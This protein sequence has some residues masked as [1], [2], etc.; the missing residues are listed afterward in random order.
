MSSPVRTPRTAQVEDALILNTRGEV[1]ETSAANIFWLRHGSLG[2][3]PIESGALP[4]I[5]RASVLRLA[6]ELGLATHET[7]AVPA[8]LFSAD[9]VFS[10]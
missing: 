2:T 10:P 1:V 9:A 7:A 3:T 8:D 4:G 6:T 5:T